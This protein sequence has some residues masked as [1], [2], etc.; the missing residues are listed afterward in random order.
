MFQH[1]YVS[2]RNSHDG[3]FLEVLEKTYSDASQF[4]TKSG[5]ELKE[6]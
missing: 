5:V 4:A 6:E 2:H 1:N 3:P